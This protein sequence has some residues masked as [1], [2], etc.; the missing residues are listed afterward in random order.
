MLFRISKFLLYASAFTVVLVSLST[1][2]PFIVGKYTY[3]R[4]VVDLALITF[5]A[6][7]IWSPGAESYLA[8]LKERFRSPL[9]IA[10]T[11]F[12]ALFLLAGIFGVRPSFSFWSNFERGEGGLQMLHLYAL[13]ILLIT[14][15]RE[16]YEWRRLF[17]MSVIAGA[18]MILYGV[19]A[20]LG[21]PIGGWGSVG[22]SFSELGSGFRFQGSIGNS[23]YVAGY[24]VFALFFAAYLLVDS[25]RSLRSPQSLALMALIILFAAFVFMSGTRGGLFGLI[26]GAGVALIYT[27]WH[28][29]PWRKWVLFLAVL[30]LIAVGMLFHFRTT[31][32]VQAMPGGRL[33]NFTLEDVDVAD[34]LIMWRTAME[35]WKARP[36][37]GWGPENFLMVFDS[38]FN[39][40]YFHPE[41]GFGA[42]FDRAHSVFFDYLAET[43]ILGLAAYISIFICLAL[44][45]VKCRSREEAQRDPRRLVI[46]ALFVWAIVAYLVQVLFDVLAL[47]LP[48]F[49]LFGFAVYHFLP[50]GSDRSP[51]QKTDKA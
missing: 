46:Q 48:L 31:E 6:G 28:K 44:L 11:A 3:F 23:G 15:L 45:L 25:R 38:H 7:L 2:F 16:N 5:L 14:L 40:A 20:G 17:W 39:P 13:F 29:K 26:A 47:Y 49:T 34:R 43:G 18:L 19:L 36:L 37:L 41:R 22:P 35:G 30:G 42:W 12:V 24:L 51:E 33:F 50:L 32:F 10:V 27:A 9:V 4:A 1:L 8:T 21:A